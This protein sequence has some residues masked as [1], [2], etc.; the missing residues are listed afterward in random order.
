[1]KTSQNVGDGERVRVKAED[2]KPGIKPRWLNPL[3]LQ[4]GKKK[5]AT[6]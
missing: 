6:G 3:D 5:N 1:M 2:E 4:E